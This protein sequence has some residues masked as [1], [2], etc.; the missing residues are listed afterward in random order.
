MELHLIHAGKYV[1]EQRGRQVNLA[2]HISLTVSGK[3]YSRAYAPSGKFLGEG[4]NNLLAISPPGNCCDF[5]YNKQREN[6]VVICD[7]PSL[8]RSEFLH[9]WLRGCT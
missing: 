2:T 1:N 4:D 9:A 3:V 7:I 5:C 6:Y 8:P